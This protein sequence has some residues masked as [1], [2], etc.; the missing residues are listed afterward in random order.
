MVCLG[1]FVNIKCGI[2]GDF[3]VPGAG[4]AGQEAFPASLVCIPIYIPLPASSPAPFGRAHLPT[5]PPPCQYS[6]TFRQAGLLTSPWLPSRQVGPRQAPQPRPLPLLPASRA[7]SE[8]PLNISPGPNL[9]CWFLLGTHS[10]HEYL[11]RASHHPRL[12]VLSSPPLASWLDSSCFS[13]PPPSAR[14]TSS[15]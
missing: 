3:S 9:W 14:L 10:F 8:K 7:P 13:L 4:R 11:L 15:T 12:H 5:G 2:P 6:P 1:I